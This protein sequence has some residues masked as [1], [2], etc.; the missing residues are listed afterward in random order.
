VPYQG[1]MVPSARGLGAADNSSVC[2]ARVAAKSV[3]GTDAPSA[4]PAR[5]I[6]AIRELGLG[7]ELTA[8]VLGEHARRVYP[9]LDSPP[10][11]V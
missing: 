2:F 6:A 10:H 7:D 9:G 11:R 8:G 4:D 1:A 5:N 3:F